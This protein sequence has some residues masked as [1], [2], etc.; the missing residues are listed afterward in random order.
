MLP[1]LVLKAESM[2]WGVKES[3]RSKDTGSRLTTSQEQKG[4]DVVRPSLWRKSLPA[5]GTLVVL[6]AGGTALFGSNYNLPVFAAHNPAHTGNQFHHQSKAH[7]TERHGQQ[8]AQVMRTKT[9][10]SQASA[11]PA[12]QQ[13][14]VVSMSNQNGRQNAAGTTQPAASMPAV[15]SQKVWITF[16]A[17]LDN[18]PAG[19]R[20]IAYPGPAP[21][22]AQAGGTGTYTDPLTLASDTRWLPAGTRV[23]VPSLHKY[24][25]MEDE[26]VAAVQEYSATGLHHV[27]LYMS[28]SVQPG[29]VA[30]EDQATKPQGENS[31]LV[32]NPPAG[33]PVDIT[34]LYS[35][36]TGSAVATHTYPDVIPSN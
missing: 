4:Y 27:D 32:V 19:S 31:L 35:D 9:S 30:A 23:Y 2:T 3:G 34:P 25:I 14:G 26:C 15:N 18:D 10:I 22:H 21:R 16:Y 11:T 36:A 29:V 1:S 28:S 33:Y 24:Y 5:L 7:R 12:S 17:A 13:V 6:A 8:S 20:S